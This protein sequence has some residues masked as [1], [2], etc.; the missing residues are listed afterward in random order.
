[1]DAARK[2]RTAKNMK[3]HKRF[4]LIYSIFLLAFTLF[5][6]LEAFVIPQTYQVVAET[7]K[8][9]VVQETGFTDAAGEGGDGV[10]GYIAA[11]AGDAAQSTSH[12]ASSSTSGAGSSTDTAADA[13]SGTTASSDQKTSETYEI[14]D[15]SYYSDGVSIEIS[16]Y[17]EYD[18]VI[19]VAD[20][21]L[22][23]TSRLSTAFAN[24]TYGKNITETT[25]QI[26]QSS[27]GILAIN[28][29]YYSARRGYVIRNGVLYSETSADDD[30]EDLVIWSDGS[31]EVIREGDYTAE[32]LLNKGA[33]QVFCFGPGLITNGQI[34][35]GENEEV[36]KS[37]AS[38]PRT[39]IGQIGEGHYVM[40]VSDGRTSESR[41]LS[42]YQ[43]AEFMEG[44]GCQTAYNLDGGGSSTMVFNGTVINKPTT[45]GNNIKERSVSDIVYI[46]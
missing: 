22:D 44:L 20:I 41:G 10:I 12:G 19:Y 33:Q 5:T 34:S 15:S 3:A 29:D 45:N 26:L 39:A 35:V 40:V 17:Y 43:L 30:Q 18:T 42:L 13:A 28:G 16:T 32:E 36:G 14:T 4:S 24:D 23:D 31:M 9:E 37:M 6:V 2:V 38:N 1:M 7:N 21:L 11:D 25:S 8:A 27:G 46:Y